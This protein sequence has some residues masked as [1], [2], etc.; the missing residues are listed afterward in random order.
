MK[1]CIIGGGNMGLTYAESF[2][3]SGL[4][5]ESR[6]LI[7]ETNSKQQQVIDNKNYTWQP[8]LTEKVDEYDVVILAIKPQHCRLVLERL[9]NLLTSRKYILSIMAG[10]SLAFMESYLKNHRLSEQKYNKNTGFFDAYRVFATCLYVFKEVVTENEFPYL[11][12]FIEGVLGEKEEMKN[13][14]TKRFRIYK[15][16]FYNVFSPANFRLHNVKENV[17]VA[18]PTILDISKTAAI[19]HQIKENINEH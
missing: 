6:L 17:I 16:I 12:L 9:S 8:D 3:R 14:T 18:I 4:I 2:T 13:G 11:S 1:I 19:L 15:Q 5:T 10:I 7:I